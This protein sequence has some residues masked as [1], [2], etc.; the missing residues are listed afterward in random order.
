MKKDQSIA[1]YSPATIRE[2]IEHLSVDLE[3]A[4]RSGDSVYSEHINNKIK[5]LYNLLDRI[6]N[7]RKG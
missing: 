5:R 1:S 7:V 4:S 2:R 3:Y 6:Q